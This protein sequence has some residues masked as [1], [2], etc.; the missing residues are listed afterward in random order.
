M[1]S[2]VIVAILGALSGSEFK[3]ASPLPP[4]GEWDVFLKVSNP[5][6]PAHLPNSG[7]AATRR[8]RNS[9]MMF[10]HTSCQGM[11]WSVR[12]PPPLYSI[13]ICCFDASAPEQL[14]DFF[15]ARHSPSGSPYDPGN[16]GPKTL[17]MTQK[18]GFGGCFGVHFGGFF[19]IR[20]RDGF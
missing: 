8:G 20:F 9:K 12:P 16:C 7:F 6:F 5:I 1:Q 13:K 11:F 18:P 17:K 14:A 3:I 10:L 19:T 15:S 4:E 2:S